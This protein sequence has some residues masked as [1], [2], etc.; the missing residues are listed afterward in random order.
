MKTSATLMGY[1]LEWKPGDYIFGSPEHYA[2][3]ICKQSARVWGLYTLPQDG[4]SSD[5]AVYRGWCWIQP[6][7]VHNH[8][9]S[10]FMPLYL[11]P[12]LYEPGYDE[13]VL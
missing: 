3:D 12:L 13:A 4:C 2:Q 8:D 11:G 1:R 6:K 7:Y 10:E 5:V 9:L